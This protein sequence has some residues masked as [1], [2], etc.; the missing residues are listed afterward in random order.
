MLSNGTRVAVNIGQGLCKAKGVITGCDYDGGWLY[1][2][3]ITE[4]DRCDDHRN[5][6][7][8]LWVCHFEVRPLPA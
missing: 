4:G 1:R 8:E 5:A 6:D 7:G 3:D 2:I